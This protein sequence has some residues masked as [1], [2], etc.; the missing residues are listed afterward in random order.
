[1]KRRV[2]LS[3]RILIKCAKKKREMK[4]PAK[5]KPQK[6]MAKR[7]YG[8]KQKK[9]MGSHLRKKVKV[10][11]SIK[12]RFYCNEE[13]RRKNGT[14]EYDECRHVIPAEHSGSRSQARRYFI[15]FIKAKRMNEA[16]SPTWAKERCSNF[17]LTRIETTTVKETISR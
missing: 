5:M 10:E 2:D 9:R 6:M 13:T 3:S 12:Y 17:V 8:K 14:N 11:Y 4:R 7:N 15:D 1:M 16:S